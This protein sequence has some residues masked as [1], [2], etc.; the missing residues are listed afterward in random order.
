MI[1]AFIVGGFVLGVIATWFA[2]KGAIY[3]AFRPF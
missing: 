3:A 1:A 2:I